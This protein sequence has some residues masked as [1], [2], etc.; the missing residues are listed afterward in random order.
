[1]LLFLIIIISACCGDECDRNEKNG[2][3]CLKEN[4]VP[5]NKKENIDVIY[6]KSEKS[7]M[8]K[9]EPDIQKQIKFYLAELQKNGFHI[10]KINPIYYKSMLFS[11]TIYYKG[12]D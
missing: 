3:E 9:I 7:G 5:C 2:I 1:M 10:I 6:I 11:A 8:E 4:I 12:G